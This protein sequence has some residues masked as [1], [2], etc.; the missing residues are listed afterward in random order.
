MRSS[1]S[2]PTRRPR[3]VTELELLSSSDGTSSGGLGSAASSSASSADSRPADMRTRRSSA[4]PTST[5]KQKRRIFELDLLSSDGTSSG[6]IGSIGSASASSA[7]SSDDAAA[8]PDVGFAEHCAALSIDAHGA[9][10]SKLEQRV[11]GV[12]R[13]HLVGPCGGA[14]GL[15]MWAGTCA[16]CVACLGQVTAARMRRSAN[17]IQA[18]EWEVQI[19]LAV[20]GF[21]LMEGTVILGRACL[22]ES[23]HMPAPRH[24][25]L[26]KQVLS[27]PVS[28]P[29]QRRIT[30]HIHRSRVLV[31]M[32]AVAV[33]IML[34]G[35]LEVLGGSVDETSTIVLTL[36]S[37]ATLPPSFFI[38]TGWMLCK[39][40]MASFLSRF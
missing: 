9:D 4:P 25:A 12:L 32:F 35:H 38:L 26:L 16:L 10:D 28:A 34:R 19:T 31:L 7:A 29:L 22:E 21:L 27:M 1:S 23:Q 30:Q 18:L 5:K 2:S 17:N 24:P 8:A 13:A 20:V 15:R 14:K 11:A 37:L 33:I 36:L 6:G 3:R 39:M 40:D